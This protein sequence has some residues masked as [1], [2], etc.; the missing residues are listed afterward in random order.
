MLSPSVEASEVGVAGW[1]GTEILRV[2][3]LAAAVVVVAVRAHSENPPSRWSG[4]W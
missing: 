3:E 2:V 4:S 1:D